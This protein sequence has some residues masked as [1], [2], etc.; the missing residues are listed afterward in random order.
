MATGAILTDM[1]QLVNAQ[2]EAVVAGDW[3]TLQAGAARHEELLAA[4]ETAEV[5]LP[6]TEL[7]ALCQDLE[8]A[9]TKLQSL[10][11]AGGARTD[12]LLRLYLRGGEPRRSG[13]PI[14]PWHGP[15]ASQRLNRRT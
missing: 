9:K 8:W 6:A 2:T 15:G 5:D 10:L 7:R 12:F 3:A 13:Y 11:E 4:L 1:L 14:D